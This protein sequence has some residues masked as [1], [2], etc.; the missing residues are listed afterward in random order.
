MAEAESIE[1]KRSYFG[2]GLFGDEPFV[3][4]YGEPTLGIREAYA[5]GL[6]TDEVLGEMYPQWDKKIS[7]GEAKIVEYDIVDL[8]GDVSLRGVSDWCDRVSVREDIQ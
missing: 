4:P 6:V 3:A 7:P 1:R 5:R 8:S 2:F